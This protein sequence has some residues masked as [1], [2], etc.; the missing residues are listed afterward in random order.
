MALTRIDDIQLYMGMTADA[1]DCFLAK[2]F[3]MD[4]G[5]SYQTYMYAD[6][7]QHAALFAALSSWN[8][9]GA[10]AQLTNFPFVIYTE[11]HDDLSPSQYPRKCLYGKD[12]IV[13]SDI[14]TTY[15]IGR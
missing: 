15:A 13:G 7:S 10:P 5:V 3:L 2:Q 1:A 12:A 6:D 8:V 11:V 14:A 4:N 9:Q